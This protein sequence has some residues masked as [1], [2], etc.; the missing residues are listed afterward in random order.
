MVKYQYV[1]N[2]VLFSISILKN[3]LYTINIIALKMV[4]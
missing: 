3:R 1:I 4:I 2:S